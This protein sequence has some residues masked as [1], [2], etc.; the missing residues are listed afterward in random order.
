MAVHDEQARLVVE[1]LA[2]LLTLAQRRTADRAL[3]EAVRRMSQRHDLG[4]RPS[5][6]RLSTAAELLEVTVPTV[7]SWMSHGLLEAVPGEGVARVSATS[8]ARV[9]VVLREL[10]EDESGR[11]LA[12]VID[13]LR[14]RDL[15]SRAQEALAGATDFVEYGEFELEELL[16]S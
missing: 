9:L 16:R 3:H 7:R 2:D 14:D 6:V 10:G 13:A 8:L 12:R 5:A 15:L 4:P 1:D 11:R